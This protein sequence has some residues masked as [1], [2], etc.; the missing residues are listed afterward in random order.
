MDSILVCLLRGKM[1][2]VD[3]RVLDDLESFAYL[4]WRCIMY[5]CSEE[6]VNYVTGIGGLMVPRL[7]GWRGDWPGGVVELQLPCTSY[8]SVRSCTFD[9]VT[10]VSE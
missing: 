10:R 9:G 3:L 5:R 1:L 7:L 8:Q 4:G 6:R 2:L